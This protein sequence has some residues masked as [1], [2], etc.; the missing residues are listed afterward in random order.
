[1]DKPIL[2]PET[3]TRMVGRTTDAEE[4]NRIAE[5]YEAEG[6]DTRILRRSQAG[7]TFYE[8]WAMKKPDIFMAGPK[9]PGRSMI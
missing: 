4:A 9:S 6:Y 5:R 8:I 1:M 3:M 7:V 2:G